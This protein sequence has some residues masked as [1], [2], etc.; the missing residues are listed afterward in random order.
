MQVRVY[1]EDTD[2][3]GVVY[4]AGYIRFFER[5]RTEYLRKLGF[6]VAELA[7]EGAVFPVVRMEVEFLAAARHDDLLEITTSPERVAGATL[8]FRQQALR[9]ADGKLLVSALVTL[10]CIGPDNRARRIP[11]QIRQVLN[12]KDSKE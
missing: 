6:S 11:G 7:H 9:S 8:S 10:A 4:H 2:A 1:Y 5:A 3:A 12:G